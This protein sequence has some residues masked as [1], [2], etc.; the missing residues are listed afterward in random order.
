MRFRGIL[1]GLVMA[2]A[3]LRPAGAADPQRGE[4]L[5]MT[6]P[7][8]GQLGCADCHSDNP[9][10]N[11]FGNI[12]VG[13]NQVALIQRAVQSNTGGMGY[14]AS[15]YDETDLADIAAWLGN[16][17]ARLVF[18]PTAPGSTAAAQ[19]V[20]I[21]SSTKAGVSGLGLRIEGEFVVVDSTCG[22]EVARFSSCT[23]EL[24]FRPAAAGGDTREGALLIGHEGTPTP[25]R[26]PLRGQVLLKPPAVA[27][28]SPAAID[29]GS[30]ALG[31]ESAT[32]VVTVSNGS[33]SELV[34]GPMASDTPAFAISGGSCHANLVLGEGQACHVA[35]R[36]VPTAG[37]VASGRLVITH[38][39][40]GG[41][42]AVALS[43]SAENSPG[44]R[45]VAEPAAWD[46]GVGASGARL[47]SGVLTMANRGA[48]GLR[49]SEVVSSDAAF[50]VERSS[51]VAGTSLLPGQ[52][53]QLLL[54]W[55]PLRD[56]ATSAELR[57]AAVG[58]ATPLRV[59]LAG[60]AATLLVQASP[61]RLA[62]E[63]RIG[64]TQTLPVQLV[65]RGNAAA[66]LGAL[67]LSGPESSDFAI[68][69]DSACRTGTRLEAGSVCTLRLSFRPSA[70]GE[71]R[72]RLL[73]GVEGGA[74]AIGVEL[75]GQGHAR[76]TPAL[77][78]DAGAL[79]FR[80][81]TLVASTAPQSL[82]LTLA[83]RGGAPLPAPALRLIGDAA[84]AFELASGCGADLAPGGSCRVELRF[85]P[86]ALGTHRASLRIGGP[87]GRT[88]AAV[89]IEGRAVVAS[90]ALAALPS[91]A[92]TGLVWDQSHTDF[93][94]TAMGEASVA[95][96]LN[97]VN[98]GAGTTLPLVFAISGSAGAEFS[99]DAGSAC[100]GAILAPGTGCALR[101][102]FH[103]AA[104]GERRALLQAT[105]AGV[106]TIELTGSGLAP[107]RGALL[108]EPGAVVFQARGEGSAAATQRLLIANPGALEVT[109]SALGLQG[110]GFTL[111]SSGPDTC[112]SG[113]AVLLPGEQCSVEIG[114]PG[115]AAASNGALLALTAAEPFASTSVPV[116][117][118]EDPAQRS[119]AGTGG[120]ALAG[121]WAAALLLVVALCAGSARRQC[122]HG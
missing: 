68:G 46:F 29:F 3:A 49:L 71:R 89:S 105:G 11:N 15:Y 35:L 28:V 39:G 23:V 90:T 7:V 86:A 26:L 44:A 2:L 13:R 16:A 84:A 25:V 60:R 57:V 107:A 17:P 63:E 102:R 83:N 32:R 122:R 87:L 112:P 98:R 96:V 101:L 56:G 85:V 80:E 61:S 110:S 67:S 108:A 75:F 78:L 120:G 69:G 76:A 51:C 45:L 88:L 104:G 43:G 111:A 74:P 114:W 93:G 47:V 91:V 36:L 119:N 34:L 115:G 118:S 20:T 8:A 5:F 53:C 62:F 81:R 94:T 50:S 10:L 21:S 24:A 33:A 52:A 100:A 59:P 48:R 106:P 113:E 30:V 22:N 79:R 14:F 66:V 109:L 54:A 58:L 18:A 92:P 27:R 19:R 41:G 64:A 42:A 55:T 73:A 117:V 4:R 72:A 38:D 103:P 121:W 6:P 31:L 40:V 82:H 99:I 116:S 1:A 37:G 95:A 65:N 9:Q 97:L 12:W 70:G 77:W